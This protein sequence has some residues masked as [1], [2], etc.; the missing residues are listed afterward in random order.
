MN[1]K[2]RVATYVVLLSILILSC[3][4]KD[5][6]NEK[7][8]SSTS[9]NKVEFLISEETSKEES[10]SEEMPK[11][12]LVSEETFKED[13]TLEEQS[14]EKAETNTIEER[15]Y[16]VDVFIT[17]NS[18]EEEYKNS[19]EWLQNRIPTIE[20][21]TEGEYEKHFRQRRIDNYI[22]TLQIY[23]DF[24]DSLG[25]DE[26]TYQKAIAFLLAACKMHRGYAY[27]NDS[28]PNDWVYTN[29]PIG[30]YFFSYGQESMDEMIGEI[31]D[32]QFKEYPIDTSC[33]D[34]LEVRKEF[35]T[36]NG[37]DL[38]IYNWIAEAWEK[39]FYHCIQVIEQYMS[40]NHRANEAENLR[41]FEEYVSEWANKGE[42]Y[43]GIGIVGSSLLYYEYASRKEAFRTGT[44][45]LLMLCEQEGITYE[46]LYDYE[47]DEKRY[48]K[49]FDSLSNIIP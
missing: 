35:S 36:F 43:V 3:A 18:Y 13:F 17:G 22:D 25:E 6:A 26:N 44:V 24:I 31:M 45:V 12:D 16:G 29:N 9:E 19:I 41:A 42:E 32:M 39:E 27:E 4:K 28:M 48:R 7:F 8:N 23:M 20:P 34:L 5:D 15:K 37:Y 21:E 14:T 33:Y 10:A 47:K 46:Y 38:I 40:D 30:D 1:K 49:F 2:I 11:E